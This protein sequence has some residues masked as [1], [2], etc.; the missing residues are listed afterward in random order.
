MF[1][2]RLKRGEVFVWSVEVLE[3]AEEDVVVVALTVGPVREM[4][5]RDVVGE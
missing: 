3:L 4:I 1:A 2:G 5:G